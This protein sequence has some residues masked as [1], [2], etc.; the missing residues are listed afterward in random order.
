MTGRE[1]ALHTNLL[2]EKGEEANHVLLNRAQRLG[3]K[4]EA[5][6]AG[7][8]GEDGAGAPRGRCCG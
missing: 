1:E 5:G 8:G 3:E 2:M 6:P 7:P 4:A